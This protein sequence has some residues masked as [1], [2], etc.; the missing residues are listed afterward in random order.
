MDPPPTRIRRSKSTVRPDGTGYRQLTLGADRNRHA[1]GRRRATDAFQTT[2][3]ASS[4]AAIRLDGGGW[5]AIP[6]GPG[7]STPPGRPM[8]DDRHHDNTRNGC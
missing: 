7:M 3:E 5:Q 8:A 2:R 6:V 1:L 4:L